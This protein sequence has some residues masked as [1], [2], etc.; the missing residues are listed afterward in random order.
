MISYA[1][2]QLARWADFL[3]IL[4]TG[5]ELVSKQRQRPSH[6]IGFYPLHQP[7]FL[8]PRHKFCKYF[9]TTRY[10]SSPRAQHRTVHVQRVDCVWQL[11]CLTPQAPSL[12]APRRSTSSPFGLMSKSGVLCSFTEILDHPATMP[13]RGRGTQHLTKKHKEGTENN[14]LAL[15]HKRRRHENRPIA[16]DALE[17]GFQYNRIR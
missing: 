17:A 12:P 10:I 15:S 14:L 8:T 7:D 5:G 16:D 3:Y 1:P 11:H 6:L 2:G 13:W 9:P 4:P